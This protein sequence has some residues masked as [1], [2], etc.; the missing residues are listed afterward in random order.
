M[1]IRYLREN[2]TRTKQEQ[3]EHLRNINRTKKRLIIRHIHILF[4]FCSH[5][6]PSET[7]INKGIDE[8]QQQNEG[9]TT[10]FFIRNYA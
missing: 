7:L 5:F 1:I 3:K 8:K 10:T 2:K 9:K 6:V 4:P